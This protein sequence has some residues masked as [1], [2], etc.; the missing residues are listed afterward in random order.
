[1]TSTLRTRTSDPTIQIPGHRIILRPYRLSDAASMSKHLGNPR[2]LQNMRNRIPNPY[3]VADA[4]SWIAFV[5]D[6]GPEGPQKAGPWRDPNSTSATTTTTTTSSAAAVAVSNGDDSDPDEPLVPSLLGIVL[7]DDGDPARERE[8]VGSIGLKFG[9][10][11]EI[12]GRSAELG[13]WLA[14]EHWGRGIMG[15]VVEEFVGWAWQTWGRL[16][17]IEALVSDT[18]VASRRV[19]EKAGFE[20]EGRRRGA[21]WK[22]GRVSD[23]ITL[24]M[25]R[26]AELEG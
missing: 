15:A 8:L 11:G 23:E 25:V 26:S 9:D 4:Q 19:L 16:W 21:I 14:E 1:M 12:Y 3:T 13:Y 6:E 24:G 10:P 5:R 20:V 17:R 18:N 2:V 22:H 7:T